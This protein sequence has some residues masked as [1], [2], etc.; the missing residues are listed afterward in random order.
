MADSPKQGRL[1]GFE[2]L[3]E[4]ADDGS[5]PPNVVVDALADNEPIDSL[6]GRTV[7]VVDAHALIYQVFHALPPMSSPSGQPVGAV[8]GFVRDVL[9]LLEKKEPDFLFCAFDFSAKTFRHDRY[10]EYK[11]TRPPMPDDLRPQIGEIRKMLAAMDVAALELENYEAD[12][13]LATIAEQTADLGGQCILVT[14]DKDCRQL[15]NDQVKIFN[16]RKNQIYDEADLLKDWGV[17]P[18]QVVDFQSLVGDSTDNVPGVALIGPKI[19]KELLQ[20]YDTLDAV[21]DNASELSGK[22]RKE[23]LMNGRDVAEMSRELVRLDR[24]A[25]VE[26]DWAE[27]RIRKFDRD[28]AVKLCR[29]YGFRRLAD[30]IKS[31]PLAVSQA[32][33]PVKWEVDY[34]TVTTLEQLGVL[35]EQM[36]QQPRVSIDTETTSTMPRWAEIVGYSFAWK[37]GQAYYAPVRAPEG[38]PCLDPA[39]ALATLRPFFENPNVEKIGQ[40]LKYEMIVLRAAG[41]DLQGMGFDTMVADYLLDAGQRN[42]SL[43]DLA[44]RHFNYQTT[45]ISEL[46]GT[47]QK[48]K[49]MDQIAVDKVTHYACEDAD[50][51]LRLYELLSA[52]LQEEELGDLYRDLETP[53][54]EVLSEMEFNGVKIDVALLQTL[55]EKH[56]ERLA[57]LEQEIYQLADRRFNIDS[58]KQ[59]AEL[60]F[61]DLGLPIV[62]RTKTGPSTDVEA[63]QQLASMHAL[64]AKVMEYRTSAKLKSTY[65]DALPQ[66]VHPTT[67]RVHT[68]FTQDV[69]ATGRLSSRDPNLQNIPIRTEEGREIR[70]AFIAGEPD[71]RLIAADYS[72]IE[73][74][75]LAHFSGDEALREAFAN[76]EDIHTRVAGEVYETPADQVTSEMRRSAKAINFGII[77]GQ[78]P[79]G[80]AKALDIDKDQAAAYIDAYFARY[81]GVEE[82]MEKVL[83]EAQQKGYVKTILGRRRAVEGVRAA[84]RRN[85]RNRTFPERIAINT[86]IQGSAADLIKLAMIQVYRRLK[87]SGGQARMLLQIHD[88]LVFEC[89]AEEVD[90]L[91]ASVRKEMSSVGGLTIPLQVD[92]N[93]GFNWSDGEPWNE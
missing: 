26:F 16:I 71:W 76:G 28:Q 57:R 19:A 49:Q 58:P 92:I 12:D 85:S 53:L 60:L 9:D 67:G 77:Y 1:A 39:A 36:Q 63:L 81:P 93:T 86:V 48:Q 43:D 45:K 84:G 47:G 79:W 5:A 50:V 83:A 11:G 62:K 68:S 38:E 91:C 15:I 66:L 30:R 18:D 52:K 13:I 29:G 2:D 24:H 65:V 78:T 69:A 88:E 74:R 31:L 21:L 56:G 33:P 54:I 59:L 37:P 23:N 22:K 41:V 90:T 10:P 40:N 61:E 44:L 3:D 7:Y 70:S 27:G 35:V 34:Q 87:E 89:P 80:L 82:F 6:A 25:P 14:S 72:Q 17:R 20:K 46:I 42:H 8:H 75:V 51:P 73:L 32:P 4:A 64:P 55:S